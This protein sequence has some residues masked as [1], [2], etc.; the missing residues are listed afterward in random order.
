MESSTIFAATVVFIGFFYLLSSAV[1]VLRKGSNISMARAAETR[2]DWYCFFK[3]SD[4]LGNDWEPLE[5]RETQHRE[6]GDQDLLDQ[7]RRQQA[8]RPRL[9]AEEI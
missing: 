7:K 5:K 1:N 9:H 2:R 8:L 4:L 6:I 3:L